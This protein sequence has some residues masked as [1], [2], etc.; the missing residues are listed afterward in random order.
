M[1]P[2]N[3]CGKGVIL[4]TVGHEAFISRVRERMDGEEENKVLAGT[5]QAV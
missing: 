3:I 4:I 2:I 5:T 1:D